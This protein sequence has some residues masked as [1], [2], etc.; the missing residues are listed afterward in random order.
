M[1]DLIVRNGLV[2]DGV[3]ESAYRADVAV[4]GN[5]I[6]KVGVVSEKAYR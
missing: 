5:Q 1:H 4:D 3:S 2:V 6:S